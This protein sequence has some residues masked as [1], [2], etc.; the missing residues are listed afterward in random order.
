MHRLIFFW[1]NTNRSLTKMK[2]FLFSIIF[3]ICVFTPFSNLQGVYA[4]SPNTLVL[5]YGNKVWHYD[6]TIPNISDNFEIQSQHQQRINY[7]KNYSLKQ[8]QD[9]LTTMGYDKEHIYNFLL[10]DFDKTLN[11]IKSSIEYPAKEPTIDFSPNNQNMFSFGKEESGL[12]I[13]TDKLLEL[14]F[15]E[16]SLITIPTITIAP[17]FTQEELYQNVS[18]RSKQSTS[19]VGSEAGR[20]YNLT[21]A[22]S[23]FNGIVLMPNEKLSFNSVTGD[24]TYANG[25]KDAIVISNGEFVKGPGGGVCQASTTLYN[26]ALMAGLKINNVYKHSLPV[27]Y[28]EQGF[29]AMVNDDTVDMCFTNNTNYPVYIKTYTENEHAYALIYGEDLNG[30]SYKK[31]SEKVRDIK[32]APAEIIADTEGLYKDKIKYKGEF[33]TKRYAQNGYEVKAYLEK[34]LDNKLIERKLIRTETYKSQNAIIYEGTEEK[35][36][37]EPSPQSL[38]IDKQN[39]KKVGINAN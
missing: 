12:A 27:H 26:A 24:R 21:K 36:E 31:V 2:K 16:E 17:T 35:K 28:V 6:M 34:Y 5:Q 32:P 8:I 4:D 30:V 14:I 25:Y 20:R 7:L 37:E 33:Y 18:L 10:P 11:A 22:L 3:L 1:N 19:F 9:K 13:D 39:N 23:M 38:E 15:S 29:D